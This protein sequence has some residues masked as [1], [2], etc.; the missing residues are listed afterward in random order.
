MDCGAKLSQMSTLVLELTDRVFDDT[1]KQTNSFETDLPMD[2]SNIGVKILDS[3]YG[4][5]LIFD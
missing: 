1:K 4:Y 3:M 5:I 2:Q